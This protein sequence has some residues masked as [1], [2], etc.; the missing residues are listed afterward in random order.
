MAHERFTRI[1]FTSGI[2]EN[3]RIRQGIMQKQ[4]L[5]AYKYFFLQYCRRFAEAQRFLDPTTTDTW[6]NW[7]SSLDFSYQQES[8][9]LI[10]TWAQP[11]KG[12]FTA[13]SRELLWFNKISTADQNE[14]DH[15]IMAEDALKAISAAGLK[16][17][18]DNT[19]KSVLEKRYHRHYLEEETLFDHWALEVDPAKIDVRQ[20]NE[21][22]TAPEMR[23][24]TKI[25]GDING[26]SLL[27]IGC[28]LGEASVYF[29]TKGAQVTAVDLSREMLVKVEEL[30]ACNGVSVET[31]QAM[32]EHLHFP[33]DRKFDIV[34][35]GNV[36]HHV[37]IHA[38][39]SEIDNHL[40][41]GG[42]LVCWEPVAYNP[43]IN[44][45]RKIAN[46]VRSDDERP[47][48][49]AD[50]KKFR[51]YFGNVSVEWFWLTS[52]VI[53]VVMFLVQRRDPNVERYWKA[54]VVEEDRWAWL[55]KPLEKVDRFLLKVFPALGMLC[56]N[57][58]ILSKKTSQNQ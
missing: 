15:Q 43:V 5:A 52:L 18:V 38:A 32:V 23:C 57:V 51:D 34:Y 1:P 39:L 44:I 35:A 24:I 8:D 10:I 17:H 16:P 11:E 12:A 26:K 21:S 36:F 2:P 6:K 31:H 3:D 49:L 47:V 53:F 42:T 45:Y 54:I 7:I 27:D 29:A 58:V 22:V 25:L 9:E 56:W 4:E 55:Y 37:D 48:T 14:K 46:Q 13:N 19:E 30:A 50:I 40:L 41:P 33:P 28:G 20:M